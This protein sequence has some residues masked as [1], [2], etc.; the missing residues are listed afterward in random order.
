[1]QL[2]KELLI[3]RAAR[4]LLSESFAAELGR[5]TATHFGFVMQ[6]SRLKHL[7]EERLA[8]SVQERIALQQARYRYTREEVGRVWITIDGAEV[9]SFDTASYV[10]KRADL[11]A[12]I[13]DARGLRPYCDPGGHAEYLEADAEP[14][15]ILRRS[16]EYDDYHA[17]ADLEAFLSM[18]IESALSAPSPLLRAIAVA[19]A[20]VGKRRLRSLAAEL[21][22]EHRLVQT[23]L[24]LRCEAEQVSINA[25]AV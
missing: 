13:R 14:E 25:P 18:S 1:L 22:K 23:L 12:Q 11:S 16:G 20:R 8:P 19:D 9:A 15:A 6:W 4:A 5:Y 21:A 3:V 2:T 24:M 10:A 17:I 7:V